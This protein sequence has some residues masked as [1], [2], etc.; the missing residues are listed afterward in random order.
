MLT[1]PPG[2]F[3][4]SDLVHTWDTLRAHGERILGFTRLP[5]ER[6]IATEFGMVID[7]TGATRKWRPSGP[8]IACHLLDCV[9]L[10]EYGIHVL[11]NHEIDKLPADNFL[12]LCPAYRISEAAQHLRTECVG[13]HLSIYTA[14]TRHAEIAAL[15][16]KIPARPANDSRLPGITELRY[17]RELRLDQ[18]KADATT[19]HFNLPVIANGAEPMVVDLG[20]E[21][22]LAVTRSES[23]EAMRGI[24]TKEFF[25]PTAVR[26]LHRWLKPTKTAKTRITPTP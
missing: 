12:A 26:D 1:I 6:V 25:E 16:L 18:D 4:E 17:A 23:D 10:E 21:T 11:I 3:R 24:I 13:P 8:R 22:I 14:P 19:Q 20:G 7:Q 2:P 15:T 5:A 9:E